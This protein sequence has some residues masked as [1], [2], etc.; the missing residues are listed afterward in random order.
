MSGIS[1]GIILE[2]QERRRSMRRTN[3]ISLKVII[4]AALVSLLFLGLYVAAEAKS[5]VPIEGPKFD[6]SLSMKDKPAGADGQKN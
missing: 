1:Y 5:I 4:V 2:N 6:V 3:K